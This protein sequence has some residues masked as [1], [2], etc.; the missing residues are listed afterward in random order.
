ML[1]K[2]LPQKRHWFKKINKIMYILN[3]YPD[4]IG[5][6]CNDVKFQCC[7]NVEF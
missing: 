6:C 2:N 5:Q 1:E 4:Q 3:K 7:Y